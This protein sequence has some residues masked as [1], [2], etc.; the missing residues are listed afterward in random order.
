MLAIL[1]FIDM[2]G[3]NAAQC[4]V[5]QETSFVLDM[6]GNKL[7]AGSVIVCKFTPFVITEDGDINYV[8]GGKMETVYQTYDEYFEFLEKQVKETPYGKES[9][10][11]NK[12]VQDPNG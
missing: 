4:F 3:T 7:S 2:E 12:Q 6:V 8:G 9:R 10:V 1:L 11:H 5:E